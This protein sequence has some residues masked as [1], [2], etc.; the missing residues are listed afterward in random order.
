MRYIEALFRDYYRRAQLEVP[1]IERR[2]FAW[3]TRDGAMVRHRSF[4]G[5]EELRSFCAKEAPLGVYYSV[6]LYSDPGN[7]DMEA[8]GWLGA[9]LVFDIDGDH[10]DTPACR[11]MELLTLRCLEDA[12]EEAIKLLEALDNELGLAG[13]AVYSGHRG[14]HVHVRDPEVRGLDSGERRRLV[15]FITARGLDLSKFV[16][17]GRRGVE[18]L[19]EE[20]VGSLRRIM[21][22]REDGNYA[23]HI[24]EVV[25]ADVHRLIRLPRSLN[26]KTAFIT[27]PLSKSDLDKPAEEIVERAIAF[28]KGSISVTFKKP[29]GEVLWEKINRGVGEEA[30]LPAYMAI[31]L[32][33][34][35]YVDLNGVR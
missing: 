29:V 18:N 1:D 5:V 8:K 28:R 27:L 22:G 35:G 3:L 31:Y 19:L 26:N 15:D 10:L 24:D 17:R 2:E 12:K 9:D 4:K 16:V 25:T 14:F 7:K 13:E 21:M 30:V 33:L 11:G 6:A 32:Y 23:I 34:Q 20:A